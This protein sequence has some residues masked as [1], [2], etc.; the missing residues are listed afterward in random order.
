MLGTK[1]I[2]FLGFYKKTRLFYLLEADPEGTSILHIYFN[3]NK[4]MPAKCRDLLKKI[5]IKDF[6]KNKM[7]HPYNKY[8]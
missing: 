3:N 1:F 8:S 7:N 5:I 6:L 2:I 4:K